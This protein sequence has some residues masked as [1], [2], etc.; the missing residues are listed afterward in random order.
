MPTS[1]RKTPSGLFYGTGIPACVLLMNK[2]ARSRHIFFIINAD[3]EYREGKA[4]HLLCPEDISKC[5][6]SSYLRPGA[7][8]G[9]W[10]TP[11]G[12]QAEAKWRGLWVRPPRAN[13]G[14]CSGRLYS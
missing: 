4:Q 8:A 5:V 3:T 10:K 11:P 9:G 1:G 6:G 12:A 13:G 7:H 2:D 14:P